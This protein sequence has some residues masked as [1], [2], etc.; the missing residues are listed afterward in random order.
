L[1]IF[2]FSKK[3]RNSEIVN[4]YEKSGTYNLIIVK[5]VINIMATYNYFID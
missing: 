2:I 5:I 3:E 1:R 4:I